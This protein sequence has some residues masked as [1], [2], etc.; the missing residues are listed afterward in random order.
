MAGR[1]WGNPVTWP[2]IRIYRTEQDGEGSKPV[3]VIEEWHLFLRGVRQLRECHNESHTTDEDLR[4][5]TAMLAHLCDIYN[6]K[7]NEVLLIKHL[8]G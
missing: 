5:V 8:E 1:A 2:I 3:T 6:E 4:G 7:G